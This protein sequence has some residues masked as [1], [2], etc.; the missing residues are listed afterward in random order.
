MNP[1]CR[2]CCHCLEVYDE[3]YTQGVRGIC[4]LLKRMVGLLA[5]PCTAYYQREPV[6]ENAGTGGKE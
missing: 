4:V 6:E 3:F 5:P 1:K 2:D